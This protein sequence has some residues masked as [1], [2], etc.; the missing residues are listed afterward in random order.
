MIIIL[1]ICD[2]LIVN[3]YLLM[4][5]NDVLVELHNK[6]MYQSC[7]VLEV[8]H[9]CCNTSLLHLNSGLHTTSHVEQ[10]VLGRASITIV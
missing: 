8:S 2:F 9:V 1:P 3:M 4:S 10:V 7:S 5:D 6:T